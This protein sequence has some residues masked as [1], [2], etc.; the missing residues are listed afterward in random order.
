M[1]RMQRMTKNFT[2]L[3]LNRNEQPGFGQPFAFR[4]GFIV[5]MGKWST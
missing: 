4:C 5:G 2:S 3:L 1:S